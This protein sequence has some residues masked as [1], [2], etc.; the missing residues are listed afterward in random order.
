MRRFATLTVLVFL[1]APAAARAA[2]NPQ[3]AGL[4]VALRA[5]GLY[6]GPI[7]GVAG[8]KTAAAVHAFQRKVGL[9]VGVATVRTRLALGPLGD[10]SVGQRRAAA[11]AEAVSR[12]DVLAALAAPGRVTPRRHRGRDGQSTPAGQVVASTDPH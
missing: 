10:A 9:P 4:Q 11:A 2:V 12:F 7:D 3:I 1:L 8:P 5:H 6:L